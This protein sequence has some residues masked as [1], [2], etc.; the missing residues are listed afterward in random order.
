[1][2]GTFF[3]PSHYWKKRQLRTASAC[4]SK[5]CVLHDTPSRHGNSISRSAGSVINSNRMAPR[6]QEIPRR[7]RFPD[8]LPH[9]AALLSLGVQACYLTPT[10]SRVSAFNKQDGR[11]TATRCFVSLLTWAGARR[12]SS[13]LLTAMGR[14]SDVNLLCSS[15]FPWS[16]HCLAITLYTALSSSLD[17]CEVTMQSH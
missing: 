15:P 8:P 16:L 2:N 1:M 7:K 13:C 11:L 9:T 12:D 4:V 3:L 14:Q 10:W 5:A 6:V 17:C